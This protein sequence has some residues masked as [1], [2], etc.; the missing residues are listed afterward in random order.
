ME[1]MEMMKSTSMVDMPMDMEMMDQCIESMNSCSMACT[2]CAGAGIGEDMAVC[3]DMCMD[4]SEMADCCMHMMMRPAGCDDAVMMQM[5]RTCMMMGKACSAECMK[6]SEMMDT[7]RY[8]AKACDAMC[9]CCDAM[10]AK[11]PH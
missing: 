2:M 8:C 1:M 6:H 11:M 4:M 9:A 7:C 3:R 10:M 5:M